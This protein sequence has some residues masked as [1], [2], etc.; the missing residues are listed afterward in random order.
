MILY[1]QA[2][3]LLKSIQAETS[4]ALRQ[5]S[6]LTEQEAQA[7]REAM[8]KAL[9]SVVLVEAE[10][11]AAIQAAQEESALAKEEMSEVFKAAKD[12]ARAEAI[13][14]AKDEIKRQQQRLAQE[15][16]KQQRERRKKERDDGGAQDVEENREAMR[17]E[18]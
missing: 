17:E 13:R 5:A 6:Q 7:A 2:E 1:F 16:L 11:M 10:A 12:E 9:E 14:A 4:E 8:T 15:L 3:E 18:L